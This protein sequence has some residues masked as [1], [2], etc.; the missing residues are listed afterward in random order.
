MSVARRKGDNEV[1]PKRYGCV[2]QDP[3]ARLVGGQ[4]LRQ[5][6]FTMP[7]IFCRCRLGSLALLMHKWWRLDVFVSRRYWIHLAKRYKLAICMVA[8]FRVVRCVGSVAPH[9]VASFDPHTCTAPPTTEKQLSFLS[10]EE[11]LEHFKYRSEETAGRVEERSIPYAPAGFRSTVS[12]IS[13][14]NNADVVLAYGLRLIDTLL[15]QRKLKTYHALWH[16]I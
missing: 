12:F 8:T 10:R 5:R 15:T 11:P 1:Y 7:W 13:P 16:T 3:E 4:I 2:L 14:D 9:C 6:N